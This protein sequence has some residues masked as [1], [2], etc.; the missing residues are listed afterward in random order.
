[1]K[2]LDQKLNGY[3]S[4]ELFSSDGLLLSKSPV[5][6]NLILNQGLDF[7]SSFYFADC[8]KYCCLGLGTQ[9]PLQSDT[10]LSNEVKRTSN[11]SS[12]SYFIEGNTVNIRR[13]FDFP[14]ETE[15]VTYGEIG[16]SP[17]ESAGANLFSKTQMVAADGSVG[18]LIANKLQYVRVNYTLQITPLL[19]TASSFNPS[20]NGWSAAGLASNQLIGLVGLAGTGENT[21]IDSAQDMAEPFKNSIDIFISTGRA[22]PSGYGTGANYLIGAY[23]QRALISSYVSGSY[24]KN[25]TATI[26]RNSGASDISTIG[27]GLTG[28]S[29]VNPIFAHLMNSPQSKQS[30]YELNIYFNQSWGRA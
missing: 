5:K 7:P 14:I 4:W 13:A 20:I 2:H 3:Y 10:S 25:F 11:L 16:W 26:G 18:S 17:Y 29:A 27:C 1:M 23:P 8:F 9:A 24:Q 21:F 6:N 22:I 19:V 15:T 12:S 28:S 30:D